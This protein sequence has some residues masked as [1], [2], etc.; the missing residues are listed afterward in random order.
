ML[1]RQGGHHV[2][3]NSTTL[4]PSER[5]TSSPLTHCAMTS[6]PAGSP[7]KSSSFPSLDLD[8][9]PCLRRILAIFI[10]ASFCSGV[11]L[12]ISVSAASSAVSRLALIAFTSA[13]SPMRSLTNSMLPPKAAYI[14]GVTSFSVFA[15]TSAPLT[16]NSLT[17]SPWLYITAVCK[18]VGLTSF[19]TLKSTS[20]PSSRNCFTAL[21]SPPA[22][23]P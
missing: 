13:P 14:N 12:S 7:S 10:F 5:S 11:S 9:P 15:L 6:S 19:S 4:T 8:L 20:I 21:K 16:I 2:A 18:G 1:V 3:Q 17:I 23:A 22:T